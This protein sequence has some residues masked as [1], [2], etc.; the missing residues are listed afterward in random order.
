MEDPIADPS[1][2]L[3]WLDVRLILAYDG[4]PPEEVEAAAVLGVGG[5]D[6]LVDVRAEI[7]ALLAY[8]DFGILGQWRGRL[9]AGQPLRAELSADYGLSAASVRW[10]AGDR[11]TVSLENVELS[12]VG[13]QLVAADLNLEPGR[14]YI[15]G[16]RPGDAGAPSLILVVRVELEEPAGEAR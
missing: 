5:A 1:T 15:L 9:E 8:E 14:N 16:V 7:D 4:P 2:R 12:G 3:V 10:A 13:R 11:A 6:A